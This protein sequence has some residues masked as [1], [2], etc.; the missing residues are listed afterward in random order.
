V[1]NWD[2]FLRVVGSLKL[3]FVHPH[4]LMRMLQ[5]NDQRTPLARGLQ[6]LGRIVKTNY[7][8]P[9]ID[10]EN[11]RRR[12][13]TQLNRHEGRH[14]M[15]R[16]VF[17]GGRGELHQRYREG[18]EDQLGA[19]GL[20]VNVIVLWNTI[21]MDAVLRQLRKEGYPVLDEDVARL[22]PTMSPHINILG[23]HSFA[24]PEAV[25][26]GELRPLRDPRQT[27]EEAA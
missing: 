8:L 3:G 2:D 5:T 13:L 17:R 21:Y 23:R 16:D 24:L 15:A 6:Q 9:Y 22:S 26:R 19:M 14:D 12:V 27:M 1:Q 4:N 18:Q 7:L 20:V 11:E 10:D 25:A